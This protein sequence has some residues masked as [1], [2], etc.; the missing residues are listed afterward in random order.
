MGEFEIYEMFVDARRKMNYYKGEILPFINYNCRRNMTTGDI[1]GFV[2]DYDKKIYMVLEQKWTSEQCKDSQELHLQF[3][4][5]LMEEAKKGERF[6][7]WEF[8][9]YKIIGNPPFKESAIIKYPDREKKRID[10]ETLQQFMDLKI[11]FDELP[12]VP[13]VRY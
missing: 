8:G 6:K 5:A 12:E 7:N 1:D 2:W 13:D 10:Q 11:R 4:C 3:L 9:V